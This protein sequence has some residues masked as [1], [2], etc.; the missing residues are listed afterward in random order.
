MFSVVLLFQYI[1][2]K[3][4]RFPSTA[5]VVLQATEILT[6]ILSVKLLVSYPATDHEK[7][8][9]QD[10]RLGAVVSICFCMHVCMPVC[11]WVEIQ[12][13]NMLYSYHHTNMFPRYSVLFISNYSK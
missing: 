10:F 9:C 1:I 5:Y 6:N 7:V 4:I 11:E 12:M 8:V 2:L 13:I 3:N